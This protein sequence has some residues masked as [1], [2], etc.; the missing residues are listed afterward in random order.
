MNR[1]HYLL[2]REWFHAAVRST[3]EAP[4]PA[5]AAPGGPPGPTNAPVSGRR[6]E[7]RRDTSCRRWPGLPAS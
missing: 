5:A 6:D 1:D 4:N 2:K 7:P 3:D